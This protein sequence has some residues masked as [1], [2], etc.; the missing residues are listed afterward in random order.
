M[1]KLE[2]Y[3]GTLPNVGYVERNLYT[4]SDPG[5]RAIKEAIAKEKLERVVVAACTPRTHEPLFRDEISSVGMNPYL[6]EFVNIRDQCSWVHGDDPEG[7]LEKAKDLIRMGIARAAL[8]EPLEVIEADVLPA[9]LVVGGGI[10]GMTAAMDIAGLGFDVTLVEKEKELGGLL[11]GHFKLHPSGVDSKEFVQG[12]IEK[13]G[14]YKNIKVLTE[15]RLEG[16]KGNIGDYTATVKC[17]G[18]TE[19]VKV[20]TIV[21]AVG[22]EVFEPEGMYGYDGKKVVTQQQYEEILRA[23]LQDV[24]S[25]VMIQCVGARIKERGYCSKICC[26]TALKNALETLKQSPDARIYILYSD[27]M[28]FGIENEEKY[29]EARVKGVNFI[30]CSPEVTNPKVEKGSVVAFDQ[31]MQENLRIPYD[32]LVLSTPLV[33]HED[34]QEL[35]QLLK[36]SRDED[37]FFLEAHVKLRPVDFATDGV[38]L[39]GCA[40]WPVDVS[41]TIAQAHAAAAKASIPLAQGR[42]KV[43]PCVSAFIDEDLCRG[44]G[45]CEY[46]CPYGAIEIVETDKGPKAKVT[47]VSCKGCGVCAATCYRRA[48]KIRHFTNEQIGAQ[49]KALLEVQ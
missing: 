48:L 33:P 28:A 27:M 43:E 19:E 9:A 13:L 15:A 20:G 46:A 22:A 12:A 1:E 25:V 36:I 29:R 16:I 11:K 42:V 2:E 40:H 45:L 23:G 14:K 21:I 37:G 8:L 47:E 17:G 34:S 5:I 10:A 49:I 41:E 26:M 6:F 38:F 32:V 7:A 24:N 39:C 18:G 44:C 31:E 35:G 4:C 30:R 3:A